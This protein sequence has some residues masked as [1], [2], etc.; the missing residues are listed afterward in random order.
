MGLFE[1]MKELRADMSD[2]FLCNDRDVKLQ[3]L[4]CIQ[5]KR[6]KQSVNKFQSTSFESSFDY[7]IKKEELGLLS[8]RQS[9]NKVSFN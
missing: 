7:F 4:K 5:K 3:R 6:K 9:F 1:S 2:C 8:E